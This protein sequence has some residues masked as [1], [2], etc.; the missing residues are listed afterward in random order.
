[1]LGNNTIAR[2]FEHC[3]LVTDLGFTVVDTFS[4]LI[5]EKLS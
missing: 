3:G 4:T 1:M 5:S 2:I